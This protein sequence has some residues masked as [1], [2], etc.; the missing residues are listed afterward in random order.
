MKKKKIILI[1]FICILLGVGIYVSPIPI[2]KND[3]YV[4]I[5]YDLG[6]WTGNGPVPP[7]WGSIGPS[8]YIITKD[9]K[10][11]TDDVLVYSGKNGYVSKFERFLGIFE[12]IKLKKEWQNEDYIFKLVEGYEKPEGTIVYIKQIEN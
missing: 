7:G 9:G 6:P 10:L 2:L 8:R 12:R 3:I 4:Q 11:Y 5:E 1:L